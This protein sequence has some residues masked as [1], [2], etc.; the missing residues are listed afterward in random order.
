MAQSQT[1][2]QPMAALIG[3]KILLEST[4]GVIMHL[5]YNITDTDIYFGRIHGFDMQYTFVLSF[6]HV[7]Q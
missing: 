5:N 1:T 6:K 7:L 4:I 2:D 3:A